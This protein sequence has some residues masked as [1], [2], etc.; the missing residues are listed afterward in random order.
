MLSNRAGYKQSTSRTKD[1]QC[2]DSFSRRKFSTNVDRMLGVLAD[3]MVERGE[4]HVICLAYN[5]K[6]ITIW[7]LEDAIW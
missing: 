1:D 2:Y 5:A 3:K 4:I 6:S 7:C